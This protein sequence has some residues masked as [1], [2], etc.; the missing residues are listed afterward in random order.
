M[1]VDSIS[2]FLEVYWMLIPMGFVGLLYAIAINASW[3]GRDWGTPLAVF[4][5]VA[6][7]VLTVIGFGFPITLL[8]AGAMLLVMATTLKSG[9]LILG[10]LGLALMGVGG[11]LEFSFDDPLWAWS[12]E[13]E[14]IRSVLDWAVIGWLFA[15]P[16]YENLSRFASLVILPLLLTLWLLPKLAYMLQPSELRGG[17]GGVFNRLESGGSFSLNSLF[18]RGQQSPAAWNGAEGYRPTQVTQSRQQ[19]EYFAP[20]SS[21]VI[22]DS[23]ISIWER[24]RD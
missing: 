1:D 18:N 19:D 4:G 22:N 24:S 8:A 14:A 13:Q 17:Q 12:Q 21:N 20:S 16:W 10:G 5:V 3:E 23:D 6:M 2:V 9:F 7:S 11:S 15:G